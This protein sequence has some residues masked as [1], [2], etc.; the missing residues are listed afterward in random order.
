MICVENEVCKN[1]EDRVMRTVEEEGKKLGGKV[2]SNW[3]L[4]YNS[5]HTK[6]APL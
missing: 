4:M 3:A 6:V 1:D 5:V 2:G